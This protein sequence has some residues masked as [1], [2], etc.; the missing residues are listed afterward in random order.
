MKQFI[1]I[2]AMVWMMFPGQHTIAQPIIVSVNVK[3]P[4]SLKPADYIQQGNTITITMVNSASVPQT[5]QVFTSIEGINNNTSIKIKPA[6]IA[7]VPLNFSPGEVKTMTLNQLKTYNGNPGIN[8]LVFQG[9][10]SKQYPGNGQLPE[11]MYKACATVITTAGPAGGGGGTYSGCGTFLIAAYDAPVILNPVNNSEVKALQPQ[12]LVFNWTPAG[13]AG[14][15]KYI[16]KLVD[17]TATPVNNPNDAFLYN[18]VPFFKQELI[19]TNSFVYDNSKIK[20]KEGNQYAVQV[21]AYDPLRTLH[22]KNRGRSQVIVFRYTSQPEML[23][24]SR[25][26]IQQEKN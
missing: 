10:D 7:P 14:K 15:T 25:D 19:G 13:I 24:A 4:Y 5:G 26:S 22:F 16:F 9:Y 23:P 11:G 18:V 1:S 21:V 12:F 20:L 3:P 6:Y 2:S 17:L 8:D